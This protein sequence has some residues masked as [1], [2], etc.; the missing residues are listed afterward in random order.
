MTYL[1]PNLI[2]TTPVRFKE[3]MSTTFRK[4]KCTYMVIYT[5]TF[6]AKLINK[7]NAPL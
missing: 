5:K 1:K 7:L 2:V 6:C 3:F 4:W